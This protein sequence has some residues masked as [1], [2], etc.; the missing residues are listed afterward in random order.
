MLP[1]SFLVCHPFSCNLTSV[2]RALFIK[3]RNKRAQK[4]LTSKPH[5]LIISVTDF[6]CNERIAITQLKQWA[7]S[8]SFTHAFGVFKHSCPFSLVEF[9]GYPFYLIWNFIFICLTKYSVHFHFYYPF[10]YHNNFNGFIYLPN[11]NTIS[12]LITLK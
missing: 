4:A 11:L 2:F 7:I 1:S 8:V 9:S 5:W 6:S 3:T 12:L 10:P